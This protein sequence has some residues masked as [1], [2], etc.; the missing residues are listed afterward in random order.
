MDSISHEKLRL[1]VVDELRRNRV[2]YTYAHNIYAND[3]VINTGIRNYDDYCEKMSQDGFYADEGALSAAINLLGL[4]CRLHSTRPGFLL[5]VM[6]P[7]DHVVPVGD[8]PLYINIVY[9]S[10]LHYDSTE[11]LTD[12]IDA[13]DPQ[14]IERLI[15]NIYPL[16]SSIDQ[17]PLAAGPVG[18][19][20][21]A[22]AVYP[23]VAGAA[24]PVYDDNYLEGYESL[25]DDCGS[26]WD[27][28]QLHLNLYTS[29]IYD[30]DDFDDDDDDD[31]DEEDDETKDAD[32]SEV[33]IHQL[34]LYREKL[35]ALANHFAEI[36]Y[37]DKFGPR[38]PT[39][40]EVNHSDNADI[41]DNYR[42]LQTL[43]SKYNITRAQVAAYFGI[44][45]PAQICV[46]V[47][48]PWAHLF[49]VDDKKKV[50]RTPM[51]KMTEDDHALVQAVVK[52]DRKANPTI[53]VWDGVRRAA[54]TVPALRIYTP[55][56]LRYAYEHVY[57]RARIAGVS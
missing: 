23:P 29:S 42:T 15:E 37:C 52:A 35:T 47:G 53:S 34:E 16:V 17:T 39:D 4:T 11:P 36:P 30:D 41:K 18:A 3:P 38:L 49:G 56:Q 55:G 12:D 2:I 44:Y 27:G 7:G 10:A 1:A 19:G 21:A 28:N 40:F 6:S 46:L 32:L 25:C 8:T 13:V 5:Q 20:V 54:K 50:K 33:Q 24:P 57:R 9:H 48:V 51:W 26:F 22:A 31:D 43:S 45:T 14:A